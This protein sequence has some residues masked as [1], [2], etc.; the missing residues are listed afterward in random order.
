[1]K[2]IFY[3]FLHLS[4]LTFEAF[5]GGPTLLTIV[6]TFVGVLEAGVHTGD[7]YTKDRPSSPFMKHKISDAGSLKDY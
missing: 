2:L 6:K 7:A 1:M 5:Y 3:F 4:T